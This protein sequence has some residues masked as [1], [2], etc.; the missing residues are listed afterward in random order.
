[1]RYVCTVCGYIYDEAEGDEDNGIVPGTKWE[2]MPD[3]T[4]PICGVEKYD[5]SKKKE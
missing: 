1:M 2:E 4:C 3:F 5:F